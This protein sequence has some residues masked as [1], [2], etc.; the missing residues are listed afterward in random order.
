MA[1]KISLGEMAKK[2]GISIAE[3]ITMMKDKRLRPHVEG[4]RL[5]FAD[6]RKLLPMSK[7]IEIKGMLRKGLGPKPTEEEWEEF[8]AGH[9]NKYREIEI[10]S[11]EDIETVFGSW[12][13]FLE[14]AEGP[15]AEQQYQRIKNWF[16][17]A[18]NEYTPRLPRGS[19]VHSLVIRNVGRA[20]AMKENQAEQ[21]LR[22]NGF[23]DGEVISKEL[24]TLEKIMG[25]QLCEK[26]YD[27]PEKSALRGI[28]AASVCE[29]MKGAKNLRYLG[30]PGTNFLCYLEFAK[31]FG[32]DAKGSLV[33]ERNRTKANIMESIIRHCDL[34]KGGEVFKGLRV[35]QGPIEDVLVLPI[36]E[37]SRFQHTFFDYEGGW[38]P[39]KETAL[40]NLLQKNRLDDTSLIY[41]TLNNCAREKK[42]IKDGR[43]KVKA[44]GTDDQEAIVLECI[45]K[46]SR[47]YDYADIMSPQVSNYKDT[48]EMITL[49]Y[50]LVRKQKQ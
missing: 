10:P 50:K 26:L 31:A 7:V 3:V 2:L 11:A 19:P 41:I 37:N 48:V 25:V 20:A 23:L 33:V 42:R 6:N 34:I 21:Y 12:K 22:E 30:M 36:T 8:R 9:N 27:G 46:H 35:Y 5:V 47:V 15:E 1:E 4:N 45:D 40:N 32:I 14:K 28:I 13:D 24:G 16:L 38:S 43:G 17:D 18:D 44:Y 29:Q 39:A 49:G